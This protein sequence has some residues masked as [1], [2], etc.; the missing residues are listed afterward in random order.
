MLTSEGMFGIIRASQTNVPT[1]RSKRM[2]DKYKKYK[3]GDKI[4]Q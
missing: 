2:L 3:I 4:W 1:S